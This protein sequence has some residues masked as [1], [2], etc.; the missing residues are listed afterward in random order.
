MAQLI[1]SAQTLTGSWANLGSVQDFSQYFRSAIWLNV[2]IND[3][4]NVRVR[5]LAKLG[6][7]DALSYTLP[8][9]TVGASDVKLDAEYYEFNTDA[10][11]Q[12]LLEVVSNGL[13]P[14][15]QFQVMAGTAGAS[16]GQIDNADITFSNY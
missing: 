6:A 7:N 11:Q 4:L 8:I 14:C 13:A 3:S 12:M 1:T 9:R 2:D 10:D 5:A 15:I 16:P